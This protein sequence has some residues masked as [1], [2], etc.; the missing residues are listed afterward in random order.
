[1]EK[2]IEHLNHRIEALQLE[3]EKKNNKLEEAKALVRDL[4]RFINDK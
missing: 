2:L 1:M 4:Y 3:L